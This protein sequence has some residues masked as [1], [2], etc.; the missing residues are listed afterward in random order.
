MPGIL[1]FLQRLDNRFPPTWEGTSPE[2]GDPFI[3]PTT[4]VRFIQGHELFHY[5]V[6]QRVEGDL[7]RRDLVLL[8]N[9]RKMLEYLSLKP[10]IQV[11]APP[12]VIPAGGTARSATIN[13][14]SGFVAAIVTCQ[15]AVDRLYS[16]LSALSNYSI[17]IV[18]RT[19]GVVVFTTTVAS[20]IP[21]VTTLNALNSSTMLSAGSYDVRLINQA[22]YGAMMSGTII[23]AIMAS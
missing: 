19:T 22:S 15:M 18:N 17:Q 23:A 7:I 3:D 11:N 10:P 4:F 8:A 2:V 20:P 1:N 5:S 16:D 14:P 13:V 12:L 21:W 6:D 9:Q